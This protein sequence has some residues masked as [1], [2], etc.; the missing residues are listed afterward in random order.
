M[1]GRVI[2]SNVSIGTENGHSR[3]FKVALRNS[4]PLCW[5]TDFSERF[6]RVTKRLSFEP[7][8]LL[9]LIEFVESFDNSKAG[10]M[11]L[12]HRPED[13]RDA[14]LLVERREVELELRDVWEVN[15]GIRRAFRL[16]NGMFRETLGEH[17]PRQQFLQH[18]PFDCFDH[19]GG[20]RRHAIPLRHGHLLQVC[21]SRTIEHLP[22]AEAANERRAKVAITHRAP[23][24][25]MDV[26]RLH[27]FAG[28][29]AL[30][31]I[32]LRVHLLLQLLH[33]IA[34][35]HALPLRAVKQR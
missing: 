31:T 10:L 35:A 25:N 13:F 4:L 16:L 29:I 18:L 27:V 2:E 3:F 21:P 8:R 5:V 28:H 12:I 33:H 1:I 6:P 9:R 11:L 19:E 22:L 20:V 23:F 26:L 34:E 15:I 30:N 32:H 14:A 17:Q 7:F 24:P